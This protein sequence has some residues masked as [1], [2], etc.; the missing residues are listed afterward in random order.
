MSKPLNKWSRDEVEAVAT[1]LTDDLGSAGP[2][3]SIEFTPP[4]PSAQTITSVPPSD[5]PPEFAGSGSGGFIEGGNLDQP[6]EAVKR[7]MGFMHA[8]MG[9]PADTAIVLQV[10]G[11]AVMWLEFWS[12]LDHLEQLA[13]LMDQ[14]QDVVMETSHEQWPKCPAH[15]HELLPRPGD[16]WVEWVCPDTGE[17]I[18]QFGQLTVGSA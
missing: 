2:R 14:V 11:V 8:A 12:G 4:S 13:H 5:A 17:A 18:A 1:C 15:E 3:F 9:E 6:P 16:K 7:M 10:D